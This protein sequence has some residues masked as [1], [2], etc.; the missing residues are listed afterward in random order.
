MSDSIDSPSLGRKV[1]FL[2]P[3]AVVQNR[4]ISELVQEEFEVYAV[5]DEVKLKIL[6]QKY[7]DSIVFASINEGI[8]EDAWEKWIREV[9]TDSATSDVSIGVISLTENADEKRKY[10]EQMKVKCGYIVIK[11]DITHFIK[12]ISTILNSAEAKGRRKFIRL[13]TEGEANTTVNIPIGGNFVNGHIKD[14]SVVG[15]SCYFDEDPELTKNKLFPD[16]QLRL[17]SQL[18]NVEGIAYGSRLEGEIKTYV[19]LFTKRVD[20][21]ERSKI[22]KFIHSTLQAR[23][24]NEFK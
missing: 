1:F 18:L 15:F 13:P 19:M 20:S 3:S 9:M 10:T 2:H 5:K 7:P 16:I 6:L 14:I 23:M 4:V 22:R 21:D 11:S 17:H 24:D 12:I 8:K